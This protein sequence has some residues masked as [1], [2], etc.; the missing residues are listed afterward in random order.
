MAL[1]LLPS[2]L[3]LM[4]FRLF[5]RIWVFCFGCVSKDAL[6]ASVRTVGIEEGGD[7]SSVSNVAPAAG[8]CQ[9][10]FGFRRPIRAFV[11]FSFPLKVLWLPRSA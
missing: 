7:A 8:A 2:I 6:I 5:W 3:V 4:L 10:L 1:S 9:C 11:V